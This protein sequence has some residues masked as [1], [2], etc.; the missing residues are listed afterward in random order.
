MRMLIGVSIVIARKSPRRGGCGVAGRAAQAFATGM[1][2]HRTGVDHG[3]HAR[4]VGVCAER[5]SA[6]CGPRRR[7]SS[8]PAW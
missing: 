2:G 4:P 1:G 7:W 5:E 8:V 3:R 6:G